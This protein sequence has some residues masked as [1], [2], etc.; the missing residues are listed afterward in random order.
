MIVTEKEAK[1]KLCPYAKDFNGS[2][3]SLHSRTF[4]EQQTGFGSRPM[5]EGSACMNWDWVNQEF[6][7]Q[8]VPIPGD[9]SAY[10]VEALADLL[11]DGWVPRTT[12]H[13]QGIKTKMKRNRT[14]LTTEYYPPMEEQRQAFLA[15]GGDKNELDSRLMT[16][17]QVTYIAAQKPNP[18][19]NGQCLRAVYYEANS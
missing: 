1:G 9:Y 5:C 19:R 3:T 13:W 8:E 12:D 15:N 4:D 2:Q 10:T 18:A 7:Y 6:D 11:T 14:R 17:R 16:Q